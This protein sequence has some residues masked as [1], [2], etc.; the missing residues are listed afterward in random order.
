MIIEISDN[1]LAKI[2]SQSI[3]DAEID[4]LNSLALSRKRG[5]NFVIGNRDVLRKLADSSL[6]SQESKA[7]FQLIYSEQTRWNNLLSQQSFIVTL[8]GA[9][10]ELTSYKQNE[11][12]FLVV[13]L[14]KFLTYY[15]DSKVNVVAEHLRD[16]RF[17]RAMVKSYLNKHNIRGVNLT[18]RHV[19]GGGNTTFEVV[20]QHYNKND[21][22]S[23]CIL[24]SDLKYPQDNIGATA[25]K[26]LDIIPDTDY[27]RALVLN[28]RELENII[29]FLI[30]DEVLSNLKYQ[31]ALT[32]LK[33]IK[34]LTLNNES[35]IKYVDFKKGIKLA[36]TNQTGSQ[37][38]KSFWTDV[39]TQ[40][41]L[42]QE[43]TNQ[44]CGENSKCN[45]QIIHGF[46]SDLLEHCVNY[47]E[48][49][50]FDFDQI[51]VNTTTEWNYICSN[52]VPYMIAPQEQ[53]A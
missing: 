52:L 53:R 10:Q 40:A 33:T 8:C 32:K 18:F 37:T 3:T 29:P 7:T 6:L 46:G 17:Y 27:S 9:E 44:N 49:H 23:I 1:L 19:L 16:I 36:Q 11:I 4:G 48:Q 38:S 30:F 13:P 28:S 45:C 12:T 39:L 14:N 34:N 22:V 35:P 42:F 47:I 51:D 26:V 20:K 31:P 24:D 15:L 5:L 41:G 21:G 25:Q 50:G 2:N 43:C